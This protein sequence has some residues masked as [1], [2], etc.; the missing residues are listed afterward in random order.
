MLHHVISLAASVG[1]LIIHQID[2]SRLWTSIFKRPFVTPNFQERDADKKTL[3]AVVYIGHG[4][5]KTAR[6]LSLQLKG[7]AICLSRKF[8]FYYAEAWWYGCLPLRH[9]DGKEVWIEKDVISR[10]NS[11]LG[12]VPTMPDALLVSSSIEGYYSVWCEAISF[13]VPCP[14]LLE[15]EGLQET[16]ILKICAVVWL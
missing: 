1:W 11:R 6:L 16:L 7:Y 4:S 10:A 13:N 14:L 3:F 12:N 9:D 5:A 2:A 8:H 15:H